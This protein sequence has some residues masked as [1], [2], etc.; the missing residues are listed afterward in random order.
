MMPDVPASPATAAVPPSPSPLQL[1]LPLFTIKNNKQLSTR[2]N[3]RDGATTNKLSTQGLPTPCLYCTSSFSSSSCSGC[4]CLLSSR[5]DLP[6]LLLLPLP[7]APVC[8]PPTPARYPS[9]ALRI[10]CVGTFWRAV[11]CTMGNALG[12]LA[13]AIITKYLVAAHIPS[14]RLPACLPAALVLAA[15]V[16]SLIQY[17]LHPVLPPTSGA[18]KASLSPFTTH[19]SAN[20]K[21]LTADNAREDAVVSTFPH[22]QRS[23]FPA[24]AAPAPSPAPFCPSTSSPLP[25]TVPC[26]LRCQ[27]DVTKW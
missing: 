27:S 24:V 6:C 12:H 8:L 14:L 20:Y 17:C 18:G 16:L 1:L 21:R 25:A 5:S 4:S 15:L 11:W 19:M 2:C 23:V 9:P 13:A 26:S 3:C 7:A 22:C 10:A